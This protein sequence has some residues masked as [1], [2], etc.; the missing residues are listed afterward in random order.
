MNISAGNPLPEFELPVERL[1]VIDVILLPQVI[2]EFNR[3]IENK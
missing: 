3:Y 1:D 2:G